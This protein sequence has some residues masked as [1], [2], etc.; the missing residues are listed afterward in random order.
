MKIYEEKNQD[1]KKIGIEWTNEVKCSVGGGVSR[2]GHIY[3]AL[4]SHPDW[5]GKG[6]VFDP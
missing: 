3:F 6:V 2:K 5:G 1:I 4:F